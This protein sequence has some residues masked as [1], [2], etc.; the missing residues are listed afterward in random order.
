[1]SVFLEHKRQID[2]HNEQYEKGLVSYKMGINQYS[3]WTSAEFVRQMNGFRA[4]S[5]L[6]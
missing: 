6:Q 1:M 4:P 3:D 2:E 5:E